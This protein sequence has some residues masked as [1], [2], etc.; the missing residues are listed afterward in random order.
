[1]FIVRYNDIP[2]AVVQRVGREGYDHK[3]LFVKNKLYY[4]DMIRHLLSQKHINV[5]VER[6]TDDVDNLDEF[7]GHKLDDH[8]ERY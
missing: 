7:Y 4:C 8:F 3:E 5:E 2:V 1:M 6:T